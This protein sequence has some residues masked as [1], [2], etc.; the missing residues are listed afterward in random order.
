MV[1]FVFIGFSSIAFFI[2]LLI[3]GVHDWDDDNTKRVRRREYQ[4]KFIRLILFTLFLIYPAVSNRVLSYFDCT[5]VEGKHYLTTDFRIECGVGDWNKFLAYDV[6]MILLY[7]LGVPLAFFVLLWT[8]RNR[9]RSTGVTLALGFL[10]E[11]YRPGFWWFELVDMLHKLILTAILILIPS[12]ARLRIGLV[13]T[14]LYS[15]LILTTQ[16]YIRSDDDRLHLLVQMLIYLVLIAGLTESEVGRVSGSMDTVLSIFL[17]AMTVILLII[18]GLL[19]VKYARSKYW[20]FLQAK[21]ERLSSQPRN[22]DKNSTSIPLSGKED[23]VDL[24]AI[25]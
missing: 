7:P 22:V 5:N 3:Q 18:F 10:Y 19:I 24:S 12:S 8:N 2:P 1:P 14:S 4:R 20:S 11:A 15:L 21:K 13:V 9:L 6:I 23:S 25:K 17:I 16:P